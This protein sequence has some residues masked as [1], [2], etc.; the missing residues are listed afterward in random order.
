MEAAQEKIAKDIGAHGLFQFLGRLSS[1]SNARNLS[2]DE[3]FEK[4]SA[5][6]RN[7]SVINKTHVL[8]NAPCITLTHARHAHSQ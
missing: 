6:F 8:S 2:T 5:K 7:S 1:P 3:N 4:K